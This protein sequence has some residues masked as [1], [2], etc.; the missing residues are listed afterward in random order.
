MNLK[1]S[2]FFILLSIPFLTVAQVN[3]DVLEGTWQ[4]EG[5]AS[6]EV[7]EKEGSGLKGYAYK[8]KDGQQVI[9]ETLKIVWEEDVAVYYATVP[10]QNQG[11]ATPFMLNSAEKSMLSFENP[12]HDFPV[13]IRY[14]P[15]SE[16]RLFVEVL[17]ADGKGFSYY[18]DKV[19]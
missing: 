15:G 16:T 8:M 19:E 9:K 11:A 5:R 12:A 2:L 4:V 6:Y 17:G 14:K 1:Q 18:M 7:W 3:I 13:K 10:N